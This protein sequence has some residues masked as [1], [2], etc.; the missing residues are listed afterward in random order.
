ML[1][2][3]LLI[4]LYSNIDKITVEAMEEFRIVLAKEEPVYFPGQIVG[5][6]V[7]VKLKEPIKARSVVISFS[8]KAKTA[9]TMWEQYSA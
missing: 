3:S 7:L 8:G 9:W 6:F 5:G 2:F 1:L 4:P